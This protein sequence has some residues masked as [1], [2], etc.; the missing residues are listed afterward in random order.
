M[1]TVSTI[2]IIFGIESSSTRAFIIGY[3]NKTKHHGWSGF[4]FWNEI[5]VHLTPR[6]WNAQSIPM[7]MVILWFIFSRCVFK[8]VIIDLAFCPHTHTCHAKQPSELQSDHHS[9]S[10]YHYY[11]I[12]DPSREA[13]CVLIICIS[14][15][16][17][18]ILLYNNN[19]ET[20]APSKWQNDET[21]FKLVMADLRKYTRLK[22]RLWWFH[23][24]LETAKQNACMWT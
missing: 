12:Y 22:T 5:P 6:A 9:Q 1:T 21:K 11:H 2:N 20:K 19:G 8:V 13:V 16:I 15:I 23:D 4:D 17:R 10:F 14:C 18:F 3:K 24:K 7:I